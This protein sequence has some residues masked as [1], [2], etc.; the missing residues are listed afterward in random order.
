MSSPTVEAPD[1]AAASPPGSPQWIWRLRHALVIVLF[2]A[3]SLNTDTGRILGDTKIDLVLDPGAFLT[4]ALHLWDP[5]GSGG[6]LQNQAYGYL[7]PMGPFFWVAD[8]LGLAGWVTQRLWWTLLLGVSYA[9]FVL[10]ARRLQIG[11]SWSQLI[12]GVAFALSPHVLTVLG[13]SSIEVWPPALAPW[14]LL[15][16]VSRTALERPLRAAALS[17]VAI[18]CTGGVNAAVNLAAVLPAAL[19]LLTRSWSWALAR[20]AGA[21]VVAGLVATLW[22]AVPLVALGR[23]SPP[24]LDFIESASFTTS[25]TAL[26]QVLRGTGN[27]VAYV[28]GSGSAAGFSLLTVRVLIALTV[29]VTAAGLAGIGLRQSP[30]RRYLAVLLFAGVLLVTLG[31]AGPVEGFF[32]ADVRAALD[33]A[34]APIRNVHKFDI[35]IRLA[36]MLGLVNLLTAVA[37]GRTPAQDRFQRTV[38]A[39]AGLSAVAGAAS[40]FFGLAAAPARSFTE[41][42]AYWT[43]T[44]DWLADH[45]AQ[46]RTLL[47]PGSRFADY[48]WGYPADEPIQATDTVAW[49]VR[50]AVPLTD[51]GHVRWLDAVERRVADGVGGADLAPALA[52][53][54]VGYILLRSDLNYGPQGATR[55][56]VARTVL[57]DSPGLRKVAQFGPQVGGGGSSELVF[58]AGLSAPAPAIEIYA[59]EDTVD[60]ASLTAAADLA[61]VVGGAE[62]GGMPGAI[63]DGSTLVGVGRAPAPPEVTGP[64]VL[65]DTP[66]RREVNVGVGAFGTS[67][68]LSDTDPRRLTTP[69]RDYGADDTPG[70]QAQA[71]GG[72]VVITASSS[73]G[74]ATAGPRPDPAAQPYA[75]FDASLTTMWR[76][77]PAAPVLGSWVEARFPHKVDLTGGQILFDPATT[78]REVTLS[79]SQGQTSLEVRDDRAE[80]PAIKSSEL[81][82][83]LATL[84]TPDPGSD[85]GIRT[86]AIPGITVLRPI[87]LPAVPDGLLVDQ[88][89][90]TADIGRPGCLP[91]AAGMQCS[92]T[93]ER[94]GEEAAGLDRRLSLETATSYALAGAARPVTGPWLVDTVADALD[95]RLR[96]TASS[97]AVADLAGDALVAVDGDPSTTWVAGRGDLDPTLTVSWA[98]PT[99]INGLRITVDP[100]AAAT[101]PTRVR[102]VIDGTSQDADVAP[103][104]SVSFAQVTTSAVEIHLATDTPRRSLDP[105]RLTESDLRIGVSEISVDGL[106]HTT[107]HTMMS[108]ATIVEFPCGTGPNVQVGDTTME[109]SGQASVGSLIRSEPV[110]LTP[111]GA[112]ATS[113]PAGEVQVTAADPDRWLVSRLVLTRPG[114][115]TEAPRTWPVQTRAWTAARRVV[116]VPSRDAPAILRIRENANSGWTA[117]AAGQPLTAVTVSGWQQGWVVPAG[118]ATEVDVVFAPDAPVRSGMLIGAIL[119]VI[120]RGVALIPWRRPRRVAPEIIAPGP[121][122]VAWCVGALSIVWAAGPVGLGVVAVVG[123]AWWAIRSGAWAR[124]GAGMRG[125][126]WVR[127][128]LTEPVAVVAALAYA[129]AGLTIVLRPYATAGYAGNSAL[130]QLLCVL[131]LG[132]LLSGLLVGPPGESA[133]TDEP[134]AE[135][136][137]PPTAN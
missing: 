114:T 18:G 38:V 70:A 57:A 33:G 119:L 21:W 4:R 5:L 34:L 63:T 45:Q 92:P 54:G 97:A 46:G 103:D 121:I 118:S 129:L 64:V 107:A 113:L 47:L 104:G 85:V 17:G 125:L 71:G 48:T 108:D 39:I 6:Q 62:T 98:R 19:W 126:R 30:H 60:K 87:E 32:A 122:W 84:A 67:F 74:D 61:R 86:V 117:T 81:R 53:A 3:V 9:G 20:L 137:A 115:R 25:T 96:A 43:A 68:T 94:I 13:R 106:S 65:T 51:P 95:L 127:G 80:L 52:D 134:T 101:T 72:D 16:L 123:V 124:F 73:A 26:V 83:T 69:T 24:F 131:A 90:L 133:A 8:Q 88:I 14:I 66:R 130:T 136:A 22:W 40:S 59:V 116:Q 11:A 29:I 15:P 28:W 112:E 36:L 110:E 49:D 111:C 55:P 78:V 37:R 76:P 1:A 35:L 44:T 91:T 82:I 10:L 93:L 135:S 7:F 105:Y 132:A 56:A 58:D 77:D 42:P 120:M 27:W 99:A 31:H 100:Q 109:T 79:T 23:Y 75:A 12:G 89:N 2:A 50:N 128:Y 41:I 102:V